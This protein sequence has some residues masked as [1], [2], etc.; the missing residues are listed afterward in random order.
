MN[1]INTLIVGGLCACAWGALGQ[2][3]TVVS[4]ATTVETTSATPAA[5][6]ITGADKIMMAKAAQVHCYT[7]MIEEIKGLKVSESL[8]VADAASQDLTQASASSGI[9]Q[10]AVLKAPVYLDDCCMISGTI[11]LDQLVENLTRSVK[12]T[13][14]KLTEGFVA[15]KRYNQKAKVTVTG[16]G[17]LA[18]PGSPD[19]A[20]T[21]ADKGETETLKRLVG[22]GQYKVMALKKARLDALTQLAAHIKGV[23]ISATMTVNN[24]VGSS[25]E[26]A[27]TEAVIQGARVVR[28]AAVAPDLAQ[29]WVE[30]T[31]EN[32]VENIHK[33]STLFPSGKE[34]TVENIRL[35]NQLVKVPA[36]GQ[37]AVTKPG[38]AQSDDTSSPAA[39]IPG[40]VR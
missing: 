39:E 25:W 22:P 37:G 15:I 4:Q 31:M 12:I 18:A 11:T 6:P 24:C 13:N 38:P 1:T 3:Q 7:L 26:Q 35:Y 23:R 29:C 27:D 21:P 30:I 17:A 32:I 40:S 34:V 16:L 8:T 2:D 10:G 9:V 20:Q 5:R 19:E 33:H 36:I 14:E 28:Y